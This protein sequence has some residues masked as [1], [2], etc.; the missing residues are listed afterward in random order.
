MADYKK[1]YHLMFNACTDALEAL[2]R[3]DI[4]A[5]AE[6]LR[7]AQIKAEELILEDA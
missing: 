3:Q 1:L 6:L 2:D 7:N 4:P 5:A